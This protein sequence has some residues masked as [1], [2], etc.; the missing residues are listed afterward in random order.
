MSRARQCSYVQI[1]SNDAMKVSLNLYQCEYYKDFR[2]HQ[3]VTTAVLTTV[4]VMATLVSR[5]R[6][7]KV[8]F[9]P[10]L[11]S[12]MFHQY[13]IFYKDL[14]LFEVKPDRRGGFVYLTRHTGGVGGE[15]LRALTHM[16]P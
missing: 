15:R 9:Q 8:I 13:A 1:L 4:A 3:V 14:E 12:T 10:C 6:P 16:R 11:K 2:A 5:S 7:H